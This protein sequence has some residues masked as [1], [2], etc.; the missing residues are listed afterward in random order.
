MGKTYGNKSKKSQ[1][2]YTPPALRGNS[3][4]D[5]FAE[6]QKLHSELD[7]VKQRQDDIGRQF[8]KVSKFSISFDLLAQPT[9]M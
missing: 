9:V 7:K 5:V 4:M 6:I 1:N 3:D 8:S 2:I